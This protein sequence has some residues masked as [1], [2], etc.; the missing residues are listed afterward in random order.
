LDMS[1]VF[2]ELCARRQGSW[3]AVWGHFQGVSEA[4]TTFLLVLRYCLAFPQVLV[5]L[6]PE[7]Q[8]QPCRHKGAGTAWPVLLMFLSL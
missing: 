8:P 2:A 6:R 4:P 1:S 3:A 5:E 7:W